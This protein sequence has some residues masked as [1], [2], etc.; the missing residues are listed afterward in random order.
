M[1]TETP[2]VLPFRGNQFSFSLTCKEKP[3][4]TPLAD[5]AAVI[6]GKPDFLDKVP[7]TECPSNDKVII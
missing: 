7:A 5:L 4:D 3:Q 2:V 1:A 6:F